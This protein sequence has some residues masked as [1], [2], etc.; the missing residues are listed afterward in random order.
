MTAKAEVTLTP[1]IVKGEE[2]TAELKPLE[3]EAGTTV[4][5]QKVLKDLPKG[6]G[7]MNE[8]LRILPEIELTDT[9]TQSN[10]AG[11]IKPGKVSILGGAYYQNNFIVDGSP[12]NSLL[13][14]GS[15]TSNE[16]QLE[17]HAQEMF[18]NLN[19]I[20]SIEV[21]S[22]NVPARYG[23]FTGGV[24]E[25]KTKHAEFEW[26]AR[27]ATRY[28]SDK[29]TQ[30]HVADELDFELSRSAAD[31][32]PKFEKLS[33]NLFLNVPIDDNN[34]FYINY[35][36][37]SSDIPILHLDRTE[38]ESRE[39]ENFMTKWTHYF[40]DDHLMDVSFSSSPYTETRFLENVEDSQYTETGGG[41]KLNIELED[42]FEQ[43]TLQTVLSY[44]DSVTSRNAPQNYYYWAQTDTF[45][46]GRVYDGL[47]SRQ[48]GHGDLES[49]QSRNYWKSNFEFKEQTFGQVKHAFNLSGE[50]NRVSAYKTRDQDANKYKVGVTSDK[51]PESGISNLI[52]N[53]ADAC[54]E[55][56]QYAVSKVV[57][58]AGTRH[59]EIL[60]TGFSL[61]DA[62]QYQRLML[63][64]GARYDYN[65]FMQNHDIA[66]R[67]FGKL[68][69]L[70]NKNLFLTA[71]LNRYYANT[72]LSHKLRQAGKSY[73]EYTRGLVGG[74]DEYGQKIVTPSDWSLG[75][76]YNTDI[77]EYS[78]LKTP[79]SDERSIGIEA[80]LWGGVFSMERILRDGYDQ[81]TTETSA[82]ED[83]G[84][85]YTT[86]TNNGWSTFESIKIQWRKQW[87]NHTFSISYFNGEGSKNYLDNY[88]D[89]A[90]DE[91]NS[92]IYYKGQL[93]QLSDFGRIKQEKPP[94]VKLFYG[95]QPS[96][97]LNL[98][99]YATYTGGY[100]S[101]ESN[102]YAIDYIQDSDSVNATREIAIYDYVKY[103]PFFQ[104]DLSVSYRKKW[105]EQYY[106]FT[107]DIKNALDEV[108]R[109]KN[110][111]NDYTLGRQF[112]L[113]VSYDF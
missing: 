61:E 69:L 24:V 74:Y 86:L 72:F 63:R 44:S 25:A 21:H 46:W 39:L 32:Q 80:G 77:T 103:E 22:S 105:L 78:R 84:H 13:D 73:Q 79:Y 104:L 51:L 90:D 108:R 31:D 50:L 111:T 11:E 34:A 40:N 3:S 48:G 55:G 113:G 33:Y 68:D 30:F 53:G 97:G 36:K 8:A 99:V 110:G 82:V 98:G 26:K 47:Y 71:G 87:L 52:C 27:F 95:Y 59:A 7:N 43:G 23:Q 41:N 81:F 17:G 38:H 2:E 89:E 6:N 54:I 10:Q 62:M 29:F 92:V 16:G 70:G 83:D 15:S 107:V 75:S 64:L 56:E 1:I 102:A 106:T 65:D 88:D 20:D 91:D 42:H 112:W 76:N 101:F 109:V 60:N 4:L 94:T 57:Y 93:Y 45:P 49:K 28:T 100:Q 19:L 37:I 66:Y 12:N 58:L 96:K 85:T 18:L 67:S 5:D 9:S 14:P 35:D